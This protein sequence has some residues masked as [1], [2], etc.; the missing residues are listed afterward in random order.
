[1]SFT[2]LAVGGLYR[3]NH[4]YAI[5]YGEFY[6][7]ANFLNL[8][9][10]TLDGKLSWSAPKK[11]S[12]SINMNHTAYTSAAGGTVDGYAAYAQTRTNSDSAFPYIAVYFWR[13]TA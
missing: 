9:N 2:S 1:M 7:T 3:H 6:G 12:T 11:T 4:Y 5:N 10:S 13:R 8:E